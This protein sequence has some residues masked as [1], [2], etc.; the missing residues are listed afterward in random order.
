MVTTLAGSS[1][2]LKDGKGLAASFNNPWACAYLHVINLCTSATTTTIQFENSQWKAVHASKQLLYNLFRSQLNIYSGDVTTF[3]EKD[4]VQ[5]PHDIV[6][7][8]RANCL[9]VTTNAANT[10]IK[11][12]SSG[13]SQASFSSFLLDDEHKYWFKHRSCQPF[14]R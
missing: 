2:G 3:V 5:S 6:M 10:I 8:F 13:I 4:R 11:I 9:F 14:C 12:S 1:Q 7:N